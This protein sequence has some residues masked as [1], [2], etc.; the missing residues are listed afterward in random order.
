MEFSGQAAVSNIDC[1]RV[2]AAVG[3]QSSGDMIPRDLSPIFYAYIGYT[4]PH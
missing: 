3:C 1:L 2:Q 4:N